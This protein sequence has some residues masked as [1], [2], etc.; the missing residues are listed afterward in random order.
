MVHLHLNRYIIVTWFEIIYAP[1]KEIHIQQEQLRALHS[2]GKKWRGWN[3][4]TEEMNVSTSFTII[5]ISYI[6][7][8]YILFVFLI[9]IYI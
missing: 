7:Y 3:M 9:N 5:I 8:I 6:I 2:N 1:E 4:R